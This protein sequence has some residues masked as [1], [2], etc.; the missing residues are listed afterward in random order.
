MLTVYRGI[1]A[2]GKTVVF[3]DGDPDMLLKNAMESFSGNEEGDP[4]GGS[5][6]TSIGKIAKVEIQPE[7]PVEKLVCP[8]LE[9]ATDDQVDE[10]LEN[11]NKQLAENGLR[12]IDGTAETRMVKVKKDDD[13]ADEDQVEEEEERTVLAVVLEPN[14]GEDG[15]PLDPDLQGD[16][17]N[18]DAVRNTAWGWMEKGGKI[19]LMHQ[20]DITDKVAVIE[21][22]VALAD[23]DFETTSD[24]TYKIRKGV[25]VLRLKIYDDLLWKKAKDGTL[26]AFS[27]GGTAQVQDL[28][29]GSGKE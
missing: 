7:K 11:L 10:E 23:F 26:G 5:C 17:Y 4:R 8:E 3:L 19:G 29:D 16:I 14:D 21:S 20:L 12:I 2:E 13:D 15:N 18:K 28:T 25:W 9:D 22:Y 27:V 6:A 1:D 24:G